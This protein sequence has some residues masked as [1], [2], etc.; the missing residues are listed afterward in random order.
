LAFLF[1]LPTATLF[2]MLDP[3]LFPAPTDFLSPLDT[4]DWKS[5]KTDPD[6]LVAL[7]LVEHQAYD[8]ALVKVKAILT[9]QPDSAAAHEVLGALG[10]SLRLPAG[11]PVGQGSSDPGEHAIVGGSADS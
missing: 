8:E 7:Q 11:V 9:E 4:R 5:A 6:L 2:G 1:L 3:S 10:V